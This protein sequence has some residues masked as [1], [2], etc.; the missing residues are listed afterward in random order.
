MDQAVQCRKK[1]EGGTYSLRVNPKDCVG[2]LQMPE[3]DRFRDAVYA[4][5]YTE[6][7][8]DRYGVSNN[9]KS[10]IRPQTKTNRE[11]F[12]RNESLFVFV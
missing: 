9:E 6:L 10:Q 8:Y 11:S 12:H 1:V 5:V 3:L 7:E 4:H 2:M